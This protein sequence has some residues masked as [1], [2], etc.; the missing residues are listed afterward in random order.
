VNRSS[1]LILGK[2]HFE[3]LDWSHP[4][5]AVE[6]AD[7]LPGPQVDGDVQPSAQNQ[8]DFTCVAISK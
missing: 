5:A 8:V 2:L 6:P 1:E 4:S 3:G 7:Y